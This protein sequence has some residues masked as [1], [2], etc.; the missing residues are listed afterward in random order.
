MT[1]EKAGIKDLSVLVRDAEEIDRAINHRLRV[2]TPHIP[3]EIDYSLI[4]R[5]EIYRN[6]VCPAIIYVRGSFTAIAMMCVA[7][8][9]RFIARLHPEHCLSACLSLCVSGHRLGTGETR[10]SM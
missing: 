9:F 4:S 5:I 7:T 8:G 10:L 1:D 2:T 3:R 6:P